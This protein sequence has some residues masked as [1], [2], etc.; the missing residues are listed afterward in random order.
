M[1]NKIKVVFGSQHIAIPEPVSFVFETENEIITDVAV[2]VGYVHRGIEQAAVTKFNFNNVQYLLARVCG[3]CSITHASAY[4]H[5][6]EKLL[7]V[8]TNKKI[9]YLRTLVVELDRIHSHMLANGH[10]AEV[11]GYENLFMQTV[12][13]REISTEILEIITGNR[14]QY[15]YYKIG[16]VSRD[17]TVENEKMIR[18]RLK[19]LRDH[20]LKL[21]EFFETDYTLGLKT[22]GVGVVTY[23]MAKKYNTAG[24][25]ARASGLKTD[26]RAEFDFLPYEELGYEMQLRTEG[27]VWA[28]NMVRFD[29]ILNSIDI[30]LKVL[31]GLGEGDIQVK[32]KGRPKGETFVR[33]EAPR[34]E[35]F[36]YVKG[37]GTKVM[38]RVRVRVPTYAN[39]PV[40]KELFVGSKYS[41]AQAI[42][43]SFDPCLSC[44]AR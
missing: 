13:Y 9:D 10:V 30:C 39:V 12:K 27:D 21:M 40:L 28:R 7:G 42:V 32:V 44:T 25:I 22:K 14:V 5:G 4:I 37:N 43:L 1:G 24:P 23:E 15:D 35:C 17:L 19:E 34:G 18:T 31:D 8:E 29:E 36:Y 2:D 3:F 6:V 33:V 16:G 11:C 26:A 38:E 20:V 41:D